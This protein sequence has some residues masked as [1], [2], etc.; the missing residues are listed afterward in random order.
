M[1]YYRIVLIGMFWIA[2]LK[3]QTSVTKIKYIILFDRNIT[4][5]QFNSYKEKLDEDDIIL[6]YNYPNKGLYIFATSEDIKTFVNDPLIISISEDQIYNTS[7]F[8]SE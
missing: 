3:C 1:F 8:W 5:E 6:T 4:Q 2:G 7:S